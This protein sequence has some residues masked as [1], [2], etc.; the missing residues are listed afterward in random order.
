M[1]V[2]TVS[3]GSSVS[4]SHNNT[5]D[6]VLSVGFARLGIEPQVHT[7][8]NPSTTSKSEPFKNSKQYEAFVNALSNVSDKTATDSLQR[9][10]D[11]MLNEMKWKTTLSIVE[12]L[13]DSKD[14]CTTFCFGPNPQ[15][16]VN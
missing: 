6:Q 3:T 16:C 8:T 11:E 4:R 2:R 9:L 1:S 5:L 13:L 14:L 12:S 7:G 10:V 15:S